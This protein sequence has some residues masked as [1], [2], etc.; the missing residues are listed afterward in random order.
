MQLGGFEYLIG[1]AEC[2]AVD[3]EL[4]PQ[5]QR[6][7]R[8]FLQAAEVAQ[9]AAEGLPSRARSRAPFGVRLTQSGCSTEPRTVPALPKTWKRTQPAM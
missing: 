6:G 1:H 4:L 5:G 3:Q 9:V 8:R 2:D 7:R